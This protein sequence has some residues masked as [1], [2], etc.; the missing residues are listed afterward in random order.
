MGIATAEHTLAGLQCLLTG[1]TMARYMVW[2]DIRAIDYL[3]TRPEVDASRIGIVGN[4]GGGM[5]SAYLALAD[6]RLAVS[7]PSCWM[8]SS[9]TIWSAPGPQD[10]EQNLPK[11]ISEGLGGSDFAIGFAPK[12]FLF[13]TATRD[14]FPIEGARRAYAEARGV[15]QTL[16]HEDRAGFFEYDDEHSWS[17]PRREATYRWLEKWLLGRDDRAN[18]GAEEVERE[19]DLWAA[20]EGQL[21]VSLGGETV[22]SLNRKL[23]DR[24]ALERPHLEP[25]ALRSAIRRTLEFEDPP[26]APPRAVP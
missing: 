13:L 21:A 17:Q 20:P 25:A 24:E 9:E 4:S 5:Q 1:T 22:Q 6:P 12:P 11:F 19:H 7:A 2:D 8:N 14:F 26:T 16:G 3:T 10:A 18:E 15:Y 23:A